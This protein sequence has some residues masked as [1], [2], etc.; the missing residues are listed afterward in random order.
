[1]VG[2][3]FLFP[4]GNTP[5]REKDEQTSWGQV[6]Q[7]KGSN[8]QDRASCGIPCCLPVSVSASHQK[9]ATFTGQ[10]SRTTH[11]CPPWGSKHARSKDV[12]R[13]WAEY[14]LSTSCQ[15]VIV[16]CLCFSIHCSV[17][18]AKAVSKLQL[19]I[20]YA[21][22]RTA[23]CLAALLGKYRNLGYSSKP[24]KSWQKLDKEFF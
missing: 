24:T 18:Q 2:L 6:L 22:I 21:T 23:P 12:R 14:K 15:S 17:C 9:G 20:A 10:R 19:K 4:H 13:A 7:G 8:E 11:R 16:Y 5:L 3:F 1:M